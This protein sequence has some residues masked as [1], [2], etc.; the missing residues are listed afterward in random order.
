MEARNFENS[1]ACKML[2]TRCACCGSKLVDATSVEF[3]IGPHCRKAHGYQDAYPL[4]DEMVDSVKEILANH[5]V[6]SDKL[7][8]ALSGESTRRAANLLVHFIAMNQ[9][10][11][12]VFAPMKALEVMGYKVLADR[13]AKK[14]KPLKVDLVEGRYEIMTPGYVAGWVDRVK[15]IKGRKYNADRKSWSVPADSKRELW[16]AL[17]DT[18]PGYMAVGPK[19]VFVVEK[20]N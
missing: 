18:F 2:A 7:V 10:K 8:A 19:G 3:G 14:V 4:D 16:T 12:C 6:M 15:G 1:A 17:I 5:P 13:I 11:S 9:K 20:S